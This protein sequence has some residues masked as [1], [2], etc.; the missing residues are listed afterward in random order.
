MEQEEFHM[1]LLFDCVCSSSTYS[2]TTL[3]FY[4]INLRGTLPKWCRHTWS[5]VGSKARCLLLISLLR[6]SHIQCMVPK[7]VSFRL[8]I[9]IVDGGIEGH[10]KSGLWSVL[11]PSDLWPF[12]GRVSKINCMGGWVTWRWQPDLKCEH[13]IHWLQVFRNLVSVGVELKCIF[14]LVFPCVLELIH[15]SQYLWILPLLI[16]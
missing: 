11:L 4:V 13:L 15:F 5:P 2:E 3:L 10:L 1:L 7:S 6:L 14:G 8:W 12:S 16:F 9:S